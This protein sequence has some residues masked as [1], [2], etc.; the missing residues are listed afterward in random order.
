M[1]LVRDATAALRAASKADGINVGLNLGHAA[2]AG[3]AGHL[4]VHVVPRWYGDLNFMPVVGDVTVIPE[5]LDATLMRLQPYF[6]PLSRSGADSTSSTGVCAEGG[7]PSTR[8]TS[9]ASVRKRR[10]STR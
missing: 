5:A 10:R 8:A 4:H 1:D 7:A 2:G 6:A 3:I 9:G